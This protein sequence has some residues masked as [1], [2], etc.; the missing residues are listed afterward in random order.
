[1]DRRQMS[2][3]GSPARVGVRELRQNLSVYLR[4]VEKGETLDVTDHGRLVARIEPAPAPDTSALD[5]LVAEHRARPAGRAVSALPQPIR[6]PSGTPTA[7]ETL[8][9]MREDER[10]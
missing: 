10:S 2:E 6:L 7:S 5:R 4:R 3:D 1:M 9:R 8:R